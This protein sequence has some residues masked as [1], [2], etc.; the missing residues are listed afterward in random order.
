VFQA[1]GPAPGNIT[2][3]WT[4]VSTPRI[5]SGKFV[6]NPGGWF[7]PG[8]HPN[9]E[10]YFILKGTLHLSNPD[11]SDVVE[12]RAGDAAV[13][14]AWANH[15][16]FNMGEEDCVI[17]WWVPREMHTDLFK[18]KVQDG[19]LHELGWYE[20]EPVMYNGTHDR[21]AG[22][23]SR[24]DQLAGWPNDAPKGDVDMVRLEPLALAAPDAG[25]HVRGGLPGLVLLRRR[26]HP[27]R[28][29]AAAAQPHH[30]DRER[31][32]GRRSSTCST[33]SWP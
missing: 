4:Y 1:W 16:G 14:P 12:L 30:A 9:C 25:R 3:S 5:N 22:F 33:A 19:T 20:R 17:Y 28:P 2:P 11:T 29:A 24:L 18:Q 21:N 15:H 8:D 26:R 13:I 31:P 23:E 32:P 27:L 6:V 10:P 7:D